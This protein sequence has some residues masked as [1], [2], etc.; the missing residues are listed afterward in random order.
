MNNCKQKINNGQRNEKIILETL[1]AHRHIGTLAHWH[2]GTL[3]H[4]HIGAL[5]HRHIGTSA[6]W[7]IDTSAFEMPNAR[8]PATL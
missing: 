6:H 4:W 7:H 5:A 8:K 2:I 3:A 1:P